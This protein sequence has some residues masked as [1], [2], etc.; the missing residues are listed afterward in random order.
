[1][2]PRSLLSRMFTQVFHHLS[3][4][5]GWIFRLLTPWARQGGRVLIIR[6][7]AIG[8][9]VLFT[10]VLKCF[11]ALYPQSR[12]TWVVN[13]EVQN[14]VET[15]PYVDRLIPWDAQAWRSSFWYRMRFL[16]GL[17][18]GGYSIAIHPVYSR[19]LAGDH[20]MWWSGAPV[21]IGFDGDATVMLPPLKKQ[22]DRLYTRLVE[23]PD[24]WTS[25][26][27][28]NKHFLE[29][30]G[31]E[32]ADP[33]GTKL[34]LTAADYR[35]AEELLT[36]VGLS[37]KIWIAVFPGARLE[38]RRWPAAKYAELIERIWYGLH[39]PSLILGGPGDRD[40][41]RMIA[42]M[43]R[44]ARVVAGRTSL[45]QLAALIR[46]A[47][48]YIGNETG[49]LHIAEA[50]RIPTVCILG[51]GHF[52]RYVPLGD[53]TVHRAVYKEMDCYRC[54]WRCK[55]QTIRCVEEIPVEHAWQTTRRHLLA[56]EDRRMKRA[57]PGRV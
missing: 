11:R 56:L 20:M 5:A 18:L 30:L 57:E 51:G 24:G 3:V 8:D 52:G 25:E 39:I 17:R 23:S 55:F 15:C 42:E 47:H 33:L 40:V 37:E 31:A 29:G 36:E 53:E 32:V 1:M 26:I 44:G 9:F 21:R 12:L 43:T 19:V 54:D 49:A 34:W 14:L 6:I 38:G 50:M 13:S 46:R 41:G 45:R 10:P 28:R 27:V 22:A 4:A 35:F 7:D 48:M 2:A 16:A